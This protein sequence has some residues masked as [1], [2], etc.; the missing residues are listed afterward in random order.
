MTIVDSIREIAGRRPEHPALLIDCGGATERVSYAALVGAFE[1]HAKR[2]ENAGVPAGDRCGL[3]ARQGRGFVEHALGIL[4]ADACLV[5]IAEE[6]PDAFAERAHL[7]HVVLAEET[8]FSLRS[9]PEATPVDGN[10]DSTFRGL[11]HALR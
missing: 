7:H 10:G 1:A 6:T 11:R 9:F 2:L 5:P 8:D 3:A 4:A